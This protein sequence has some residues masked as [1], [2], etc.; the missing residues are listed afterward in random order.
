MK[1][2]MSLF[3]F[4]QP[5]IYGNILNIYFTQEKV[6]IFESWDE[7]TLIDASDDDD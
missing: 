2:K 4:R 6:E 1:Y 3:S 7:A 5:N